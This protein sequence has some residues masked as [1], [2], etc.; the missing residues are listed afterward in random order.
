MHSTQFTVHGSPNI[1]AI[2]PARGGSKGVPRKNIKKLGSKPLLAYTAEAALASNLISKV[3]LSTEDEEIMQVGKACGLE[4]PFQRPED[5][6]KDQSG[7][8]GVV[9]HAIEFYEERGEYF[10]AVILL[11]VTSPFR[12]KG[13]IDQAIQKFIQS[14]VDA[15]VSVLPVPHEYNPHWVFEA[16]KNDNLSI[17]T[18]ERQIIKRRQDLP[19]AYFRDGS[20]YITKT[21][22]IK[23]GSFFGEHLTYIES[24]PKMY[25]NIDTMEDWK[26]AE[27]MVS[28][29]N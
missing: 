9:Q 1:L 28:K 5:L 18:G 27:E 4:V 15:L 8:L 21:K 23:Q 17:A 22:F 14:D 13:F 24:N 3:I 11:Q 2:I 16:D 6:A 7:S 19:Q 20:I 12:S 25:V 10:D 29:I 26:K